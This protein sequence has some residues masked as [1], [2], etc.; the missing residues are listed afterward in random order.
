MPNKYKCICESCNIPFVRTVYRRPKFC[1]R[2]CA[3]RSRKG[4]GV[5]SGGIAPPSRTTFS[6][7][8][9]GA[10]VERRTSVA[11]KQKFCTMHCWHEYV[12]KT[13]RAKRY[14]VPRNQRKE[15][16]RLR[17]EKCSKCGYNKISQILELH[18]KDRNPRNGDPGN[19][20]LL[21]PNC[22]EEEHFLTKT[23]KFSPLP[24]IKKPP[25]ERH[26]FIRTAGIKNIP[27]QMN[28]IH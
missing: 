28:L 5:F 13:S 26:D 6:C 2:I 23:G 12:K 20:E 18:H 8:N 3:S 17:G 11:K 16:I 24:R 10:T 21:C 7:K 19:L 15:I 25:N 14:L 9:C 4:K 27:A 1:S 22:H